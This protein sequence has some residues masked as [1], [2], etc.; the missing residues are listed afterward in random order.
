MQYIKKYLPLLLIFFNLPAINISGQVT[1][2]STLSPNK[3]SILD[4][5]TQDGEITSDRG[6]VLPRVALTSMTDITNG[7]IAGVDNT[8][9]DKHIGLTI[10]NTNRCLTPTRDA[11][12]IYVWDGG[13]WQGLSFRT[14]TIT[15]KSGTVYRTAHFGDA[16]E[17]MI[18]NLAETS[19]EAPE[20]GAITASHN[21]S[22]S[23]TEKYYYY[24]TDQASY[25]GVEATD[26]A[27]YN[28][29]KDHNIGLLYTWTAA[30]NG[31]S[32]D[33]YAS[34]GKPSKPT[35]TVQGI[36]PKG[37]I[38]PSDYD[39]GLLEK[40][41]SLN[42]HKYSSVTSPTVWNETNNATGY[43][44]VST[45]SSWYGGHTTAMKSECGTPGSVTPTNGKSS[46]VG[47][48]LLLVGFIRNG[49]PQEY[50]LGNFIWSSTSISSPLTSWY[51]GY[52]YN[53]TT[54]GRGSAYHRSNLHS[55][56]C[57]RAGS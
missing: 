29:Y 20:T 14:S 35:V 42:P 9:K 1:I 34:A 3:G 18:D 49:Q 31:V 8:N 38:V 33:E 27:F 57:K 16:G 30:T 28:L 54:S 50:G 19:Y 11:N 48:D 7:D 47:F 36:C 44:K 5:K 4:L 51:R 25:T 17:W 53:T 32:S 56:R 23:L 37:W 52:K 2:G 15:G 45:T 21:P 46:D 13:K 10:Y 40:E 24:P 26:A 43:W 12:G 55:V 41:M 39:L 6:F 22:V